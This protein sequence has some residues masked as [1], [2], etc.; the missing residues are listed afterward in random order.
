MLI[1]SCFFN[2]SLTQ[3][4]EDQKSAYN[5]AKAADQEKA[6]YDR[7]IHELEEVS[8]QKRK[9]KA[10]AGDVDEQVAL[11][12]ILQQSGRMEEANYYYALAAEQ[13]NKE[14]Q[15]TLLFYQAL[16]DHKKEIQTSSRVF[17]IAAELGV[18]ALVLSV[19]AYHCYYRFKTRAKTKSV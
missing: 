4:V 6:S 14:A 15:D 13:G 2:V 18:S 12:H 11:A 3:H 7:V 1:L 19:F 8:Y 10:D 16:R 17:W 9:T 5:K